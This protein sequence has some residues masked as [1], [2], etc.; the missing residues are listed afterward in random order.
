[1]KTHDKFRGGRRLANIASVVLLVTT[2]IGVVP[3]QTDGVG[4]GSNAG[5]ASI[6]TAKSDRA[7]EDSAGG[8]GTLRSGAEDRNPIVRP[9]PRGLHASN[10]AI[11]MENGG[12]HHPGPGGD[13][14][15]DRDTQRHFE[16]PAR[17]RER[18]GGVAAQ[19]NHVN[20]RGNV[21]SFKSSDSDRDG[22]LSEEEFLEFGRR[23][24]PM[25]ADHSRHNSQGSEQS[26]R[27]L[28]RNNDG[29]LS[30]DEVR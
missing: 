3:A 6:G 2:G 30:S 14:I 28:D 21:D 12:Q 8:N 25:P 1:M 29:R 24:G 22:E 7:D 16:N 23:N 5:A 15:T 27:D 26:F 4:T 20:P 19:T 11:D 17:R 10:H 13:F 9:R 18:T